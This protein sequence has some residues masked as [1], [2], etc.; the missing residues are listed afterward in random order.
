M[1]AATKLPVPDA[2]LGGAA[3]AAAAAAACPRLLAPLCVVGAAAHL[4][5]TRRFMPLWTLSSCQGCATSMHTAAPSAVCSARTLHVRRQTRAGVRSS[6]VLR[7]GLQSVLSCPAVW[8]QPKTLMALIRACR[9]HRFAATASVTVCSMP[10]LCSCVAARTAGEA[11]LEQRHF[12]PLR[13]ASRDVQRHQDCRACTRG[14]Q[15]RRVAR[16]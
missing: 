5:V 8:K 1:D 3:A 14:M 4:P 12:S 9:M 15:A 13:R 11:V 2:D 7:M 6:R 16:D 10:R